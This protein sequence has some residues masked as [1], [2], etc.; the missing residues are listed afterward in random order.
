MA[1][2]L[3]CIQTAYKHGMNAV[4]SLWK[5]FIRIYINLYIY[6][7]TCVCARVCLRVLKKICIKT[8]AFSLIRQNVIIKPT[9]HTQQHMNAL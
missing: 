3:Q 1:C 7:C 6:I 5:R 4:C 2:V 8:T 9:S